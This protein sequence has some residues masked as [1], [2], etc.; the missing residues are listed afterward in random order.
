M[1]S[2]C[3]IALVALVALVGCGKG[4][5]SAPSTVGLD[6]VATMKTW[7]QAMIDN[8]PQFMWQMLPSQHQR[9]VKAL[10]VDFSKQVD[11]DVYDQSFAVLNKVSK[12][13][14]AKRDMILGVPMLEA[15]PIGQ[16]KD[17]IAKNWNS[18]VEM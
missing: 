10:I 16:K 18:M 17:E 11:K 7:Q 9:D 8:Q 3:S 2:T 1:K 15:T 13:A 14:K 4:G 6:P 5:S 12:L